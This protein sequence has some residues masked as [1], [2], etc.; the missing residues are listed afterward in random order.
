[1]HVGKLARHITATALRESTAHRLVADL[2]DQV[3]VDPVVGPPGFQGAPYQFSLP[4][5]LY[6]VGSRLGYPISGFLTPNCLGPVLTKQASVGSGNGQIV[7]WLGREGAVASKK[8]L[9]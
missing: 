1:M 7:R 3:E 2:V 4:K 9:R 8:S 6:S 5:R